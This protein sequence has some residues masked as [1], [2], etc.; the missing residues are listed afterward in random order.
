MTLINNL[1][2]FTLVLVVLVFIYYLYHSNSINQLTKYNYDISSNS[3]LLDYLRTDG[4]LCPEILIIITQ[5]NMRVNIMIIV[6]IMNM[7]NVKIMITT[8]KNMVV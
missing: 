4:L 3:K 7:R 8:I 1:V 6:L 2:T 5:K